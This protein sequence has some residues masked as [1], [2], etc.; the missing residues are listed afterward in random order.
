MSARICEFSVLLFLLAVAA[1]A[2]RPAP[3]NPD[4]EFAGNRIVVL[5]EDFEESAPGPQAT[6]QGVVPGRLVRVSAESVA[7]LRVGDRVLISPIEHL[8]LVGLVMSARSSSAGVRIV[9]CEIEGEES[10]HLVLATCQGSTALSLVAPATGFAVRLQSLGDSAYQVWMFD[11]AQLP[12]EQCFA[13]MPQAPLGPPRQL[14]PDDDDWVPA[15]ATGAPGTQDS[16]DAAGCSAVPVLDTM[17]VYTP[18]ARA[19]IGGHAAMRAEATLAVEQCNIAY[20]SSLNVVRARL[21]YCDEIGYV[22]ALDPNGDADMAADLARLTGTSDGFMDGV[23]ALRDSLN[24][25][26]VMLYSNSGG[27]IGWCPSSPS[28][29]TAFSISAWWQAAGTFT[30]AHETGHNLGCGHSREDDENPSPCGPSYGLGW[31]FFGADSVGYCTTMA[32]PD[33]T[34]SRILR[35][36][37]P[38]VLYQGVAT[39]NPVGHQLEAFNAKVIDDN[40]GPANALELTRFDIYVDFSYSGFE[41]GIPT[42]PFNSIPEGAAVLTVPAVG[43]A[44]LPNL[45]VAA[46]STDW[47]G[48]ITKAMLLQACGGTVRIGD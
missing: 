28:H 38:N 10:G 42:L 31:R 17:V 43:A 47:T 9:R 27:G 44:E 39:G 48:T 37:N 45:Y 3:T 14:H 26:L 21:V 4:D 6:P 33:G 11:A 23:H 29:A 19:A 41:L 8:S 16:R 5:F 40:D 24:A 30:H 20:E 12:P 34:Y 1:V 22:E 32:Y 2:Q 7:D 35:Y 18:A 36:S 13:A 25:D 15:N 46:G